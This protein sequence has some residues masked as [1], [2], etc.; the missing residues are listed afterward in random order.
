MSFLDMDEALL[1]LNEH[2]EIVASPYVDYHSDTFFPDNID[3]ALIEG[4]VSNEE[5]LHKAKLL[6]QK[7]KYV[8]AFGD[9]AITSNVSGMRNVCD[10][11]TLLHQIY[12]VQS[13]GPMQEAPSETVPAL[14]PKVVPLREVIHVDYC[15]PGCPVPSRT[16]QRFFEAI[17]AGETPNITSHFG[18]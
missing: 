15:L 16:I 11:S 17:I 14:L 8:V 7:S 12:R 1:W 18:Q 2:V 4:A 5:D 9:C 3:I 13:D 10:T 6:R